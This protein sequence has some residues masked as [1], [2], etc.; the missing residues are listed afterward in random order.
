MAKKSNR[1][2][3][4]IAYS[5]ELLNRTSVNDEMNFVL[6]L[7]TLLGKHR[8][9]GVHTDHIAPVVSYMDEERENGIFKLY[10][11]KINLSFKIRHSAGDL[12]PYT[13]LHFFLYE[14]ATLVDRYEPKFVRMERY[15][16]LDG[17]PQPWVLV[18]GP[19]EMLV[20]EGV[21]QW[22]ASDD[23]IPGFFN[24]HTPVDGLTVIGE[25]RA[26]EDFRKIWTFYA[27]KWISGTDSLELMDMDKRNVHYGPIMDIET[28]RRNHPTLQWQ[29]LLIWAHAAHIEG[30]AGWFVTNLD[31]TDEWLVAGVNYTNIYSESMVNEPLPYIPFC[32]TP[33]VNKNKFLPDME[34]VS[35][36]TGVV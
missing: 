8:P 2:Q 15:L 32:F 33:N 5:N 3:V 23:L 10:G 9:L 13:R 28:M 36:K 20:R 14:L 16:N 12:Y 25:P 1:V 18:S 35:L 11:C 26:V 34:Q 4:E 31:P 27:N 29:H 21:G 6:E 22:N 30:D 7:N 17:M 24:V 19:Q